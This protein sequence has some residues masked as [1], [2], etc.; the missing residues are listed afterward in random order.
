M[1]MIRSKEWHNPSKENQK[2]FVLTME[3]KVLK[4]QYLNGEKTNQS[5]YKEAWK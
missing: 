1:E 3:I 5:R 2:I 4:D